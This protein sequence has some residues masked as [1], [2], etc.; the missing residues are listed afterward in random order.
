MV[1]Q[2]NYPTTILYGPAAVADVCSVDGKT[3]RL[4]AT[5]IVRKADAG[6]APCP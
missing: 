6:T 5:R 3:S 4:A 2:Y 1:Q